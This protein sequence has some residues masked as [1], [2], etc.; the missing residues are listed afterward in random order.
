MHLGV[1][2]GAPNVEAAAAILGVLF[3]YGCLAGYILFR[4]GRNTLH[5]DIAASKVVRLSA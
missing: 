3:I 1:Q 5:D 2:R 4:P